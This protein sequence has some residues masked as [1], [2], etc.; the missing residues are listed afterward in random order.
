M[1][2]DEW[3]TCVG[4]VVDEIH[5]HINIKIHAVVDDG[6]S[7]FAELQSSIG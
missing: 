5:V 1:Y 7:T 4:E 6:P 3:Y 2:V